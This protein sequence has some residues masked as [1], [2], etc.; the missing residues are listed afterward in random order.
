[1]KIIC[2]RTAAVAIVI[3]GVGC[4]INPRQELGHR[5]LSPDGKYEVGYVTEGDNGAL[6]TGGTAICVWR[7]GDSTSKGNV[8]LRAEPMN[9]D[10][11]HRMISWK[12]PN[13]LT[14]WLHD[15]VVL[16]LFEK[17][18][19]GG[20]EVSVELY[21]GGAKVVPGDGNWFFN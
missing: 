21:I 20:Q 16:D 15:G 6:G 1:M 12:S 10:R 18:K 8:V 2:L 7:T 5:M 17:V 13:E 9:E 4:A 11:H 19:V 3:A 14:L